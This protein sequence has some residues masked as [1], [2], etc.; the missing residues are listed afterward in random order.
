LKLS[1]HELMGGETVGV[2]T[3]GRVVTSRVKRGV[4]RAD[5]IR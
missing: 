4:E 1:P 2:Q 5:K 3:S